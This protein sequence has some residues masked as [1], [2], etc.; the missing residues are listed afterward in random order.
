MAVPA[1]NSVEEA[2]A[3]L[4]APVRALSIEEEQRRILEEYNAA[5]RNPNMLPEPAGPSAV[6]IAPE[7]PTPLLQLERPLDGAIEPN[8]QAVLD[9]NGEPPLPTKDGGPGGPALPQADEDLPPVTGPAPTFATPEDVDAFLDAPDER[10][11]GP[12]VPTGG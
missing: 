1:F 8:V 4:D 5:A 3:F 6:D 12:A 7:D 11:A 10:T 2:D 9:A